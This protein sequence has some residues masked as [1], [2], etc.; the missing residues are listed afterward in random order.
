MGVYIIYDVSIEEEH[1]PLYH[2]RG[3]NKK[4]S[5]HFADDEKLGY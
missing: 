3:V 2:L 4:I 5:Q 1:I